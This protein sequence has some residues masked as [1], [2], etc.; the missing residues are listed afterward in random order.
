MPFAWILGAIL[1]VFVG[2]QIYWLGRV[3]LLVRRW[4]PDRG[5]RMVVE[6]AG[7]AVFVVLCAFNFGVFGR[8]PTSIRLTLYNA[9]VEAPFEW[10]VASSIVAFLIVIIL[11]PVRR[12]SRAAK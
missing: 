3:R 12:V 1:L 6:L 4:I 5:T 7:L 2:S 9:L 10:W 8:R 11:W